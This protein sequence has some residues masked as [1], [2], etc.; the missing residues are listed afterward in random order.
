M[1]PQQDE[2]Q[3]TAPIAIPDPWSALAESFRT[4]VKRGIDFSG[5]LV[6]LLLLMPVMLAVAVLIRLDSPGP[7]FFRQL[8][9]G[10]RGRL[11]WVLKFR[12]MVVD[13]EKKLDEL[14]QKNESAGGVLFKMRNDPRVTPLGRFLRKSSLDELPQLINIL[15]GEMSVVGPRPLQLR[16]SEMLQSLDPEGYR[17]RL[18]VMPGLTGPWQV[19]GRSGVDYAKMV[20]LDVRYANTWTIL[21]DLMIIARTFVAVVVGRG[22]C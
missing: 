6:G 3:L 11:F 17:R 18:Q 1:I 12:T 21:G 7:I 9:R 22:A 8:R 15:R 19:G 16:D 2:L 20:E 14:E 4:S 13:A 5:A 10:Y